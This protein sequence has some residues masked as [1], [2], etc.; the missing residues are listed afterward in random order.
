MPPPPPPNSY[1]TLKFAKV[2]SL[3]VSHYVVLQYDNVAEHGLY[4]HS[5]LD[6]SLFFVVNTL[7]LHSGSLHG[8]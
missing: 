3:E 7:A 8:I 1:K 4:I 2:F 6:P 5:S